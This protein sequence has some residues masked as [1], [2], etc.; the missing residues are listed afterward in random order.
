MQFVLSKPIDVDQ[1]RMVLDR[2]AHRRRPA[3]FVPSADTREASAD[4]REASDDTRAA[5]PV[6]P[7][8]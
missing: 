2:V 8:P 4:A 1:L 3:R 5:S 7:P 6:Q